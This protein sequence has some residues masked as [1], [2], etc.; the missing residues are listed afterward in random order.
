MSK[1]HLRFDNNP[2]NVPQFFL[3]SGVQS[4]VRFLASQIRHLNAP[5]C[6][7]HYPKIMAMDQLLDISSHGLLWLIDG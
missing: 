5:F 3:P 1:P 2:H 7:E 6:N 4:F